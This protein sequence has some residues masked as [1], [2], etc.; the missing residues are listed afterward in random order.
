MPCFTIRVSNQT[1]RGNPGARFFFDQS[2][3]IM[4]HIVLFEGIPIA[5]AEEN[6]QTLFNTVLQAPQDIERN[7][8]NK[9]HNRI[10]AWHLDK[11]KYNINNALLT[12]YDICFV[13]ELP[14]VLEKSKLYLTSSAGK[15][16]Y[17]IF[18]L[19]DKIVQDELDIQKLGLKIQTELTKEVLNS[20]KLDILTIIAD[21]GH[22]S[23]LPL[24]IGEYSLKTV[25]IAISKQK[26]KQG[27]N[28]NI[29]ILYTEN[30]KH[31]STEDHIDANIYESI[32][33]IEL[34]L[35]I[36]IVDQAMENHHGGSINQLNKHF[37]RFTQEVH[38][39]NSYFQKA[40]SF[41]K[42]FENKGLVQLPIEFSVSGGRD[43]YIRYCNGLKSAQLF[44]PIDNKLKPEIS[45]STNEHEWQQQKRKKRT[46]NLKI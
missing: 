46:P 44:K 32:N 24:T 19:T 34:N 6:I 23:S 25:G 38:D 16:I 14:E 2:Y 37:S 20:K 12:E 31:Y 33:E 3:R 22:I 30:N 36:K 35:H 29:V 21:K 7:F 41:A 4:N 13:S 10:Y 5:V 45:N 42:L 43:E 1:T 26:D 9:K 17:K 39:V 8:F 27:I 28:G 18:N 15:L 40:L 11:K